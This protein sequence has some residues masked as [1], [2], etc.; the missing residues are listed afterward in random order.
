MEQQIIRLECNLEKSELEIK[1]CNK[2]VIITLFKK[3]F[4]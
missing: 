3:Q 4:S 2:K 1:E